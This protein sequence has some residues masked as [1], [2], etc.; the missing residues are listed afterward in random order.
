MI[1]SDSPSGVKFPPHSSGIV[2]GPFTFTACSKRERSVYGTMWRPRTFEGSA[3]AGCP[4]LEAGRPAPGQEGRPQRGA[5]SE[6]PPT[7]RRHAECV[8]ALDL[9]HPWSPPQSS[10]DEGQLRTRVGSLRERRVS[11]S[12][13]GID[14][15]ASLHHAAQGEGIVYRRWRKLKVFAR[16]LSILTA[17]TSFTWPLAFRGLGSAP[18]APTAG[19]V[20]G[21]QSPSGLERRAG[22]GREISCVAS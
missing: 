11:A 12:P 8:P 6:E 9:S 4:W 15:R 17:L 18:Q 7:A 20:L 22:T 13:R 14:G 19:P 3:G 10:R 2:G 5:T 21:G 16:K 1:P